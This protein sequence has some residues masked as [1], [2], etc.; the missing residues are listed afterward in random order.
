[1]TASTP[2][3]D[4]ATRRRISAH[5][6]MLRHEHHFAS[7]AEMA[8]AIGISRGAL[9]RYLKDERPIG[10]EVLLAVRRKMNVS[11]DYMVSRDPPPEWLDPEY[12]PTLPKRARP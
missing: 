12:V 1:M 10:L 8:R 3:I 4:L 2:K 7:D 11:I 5:L 9:N 6:R